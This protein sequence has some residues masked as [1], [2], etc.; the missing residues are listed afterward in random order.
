MAAPFN[1]INDDEQDTVA[2]K[3]VA[4]ENATYE[5]E[6]EEDANKGESPAED[7]K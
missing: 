1:S 5:N 6:A 3:D 2:D 4:E 7:P